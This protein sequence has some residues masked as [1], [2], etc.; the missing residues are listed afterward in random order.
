[1]RCPANPE[2]P[3]QCGVGYTGFLCATCADGY[4]MM[5]S[6]RCEPCEGTGYTA[7]SMLLLA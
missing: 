1:M 5:P 6:R 7:K 2:T 3:G 4:G